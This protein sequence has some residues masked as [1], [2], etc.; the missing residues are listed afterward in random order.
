MKPRF[1]PLDGVHPGDKLQSQSHVSLLYIAH[2]IPRLFT[3]LTL[4]LEL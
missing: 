2:M 3:D 1:R 4:V